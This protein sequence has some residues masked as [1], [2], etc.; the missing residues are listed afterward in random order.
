LTGFNLEKSAS[1]L[2][3]KPHSIEETLEYL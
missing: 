2:G 1:I 3:Y